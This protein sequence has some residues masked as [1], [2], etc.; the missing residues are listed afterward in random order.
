MTFYLVGGGG[1]N[2][3]RSLVEVSACWIIIISVWLYVMQEGIACIMLLKFSKCSLSVP[4]CEVLS[5]VQK[6]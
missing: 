1:I 2:W 5:V 6:F 3:V 4:A